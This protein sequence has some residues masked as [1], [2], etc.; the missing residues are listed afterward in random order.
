MDWD[1]IIFEATG[2]TG[3]DMMNPIVKKIIQNINLKNE[4]G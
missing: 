1:H 3:S 4:Y 2:E